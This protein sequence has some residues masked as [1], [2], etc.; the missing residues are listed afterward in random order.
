MFR[1]F[2]CHVV[3]GP[4]AALAALLLA[5]ATLAILAPRPLSAGGSP[6]QSGAVRSLPGQPLPQRFALRIEETAPLAQTL[7][8]VALDRDP[9]AASPDCELGGLD[10]VAAGVGLRNR[11]GGTIALTGAPPGATL[12]Q[13]FLYWAVIG[14]DEELGGYG[15]LA[16][17][18]QPVVGA[19]IGSSREPCW[20]PG[21]SLYAFRADVTA[22][23]EPGI[24]GDYAI[25]YPLETALVEDGRGSWSDE[26]FQRLPPAKE[27][28]T[29]VVVFRHLDMPEDSVVALHE[30]PL[31][32][33]LELLAEHDLETE[34]PPFAEAVRHT[35]VLADGQT[36]VDGEAVLPFTT[37]LGR[38]D[39]DVSDLTVIRGAGGLDPN[40]DGQ[41]T[42]GSAQTQL[43]E[44]NV[45]LLRLDA[46]NLRPGERKYHVHYEAHF[47]AA[48]QPKSQTGPAMSERAYGEVPTTVA[49]PGELVDCVVAV[50][51]A[52]TF[53]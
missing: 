5:G 6:Q 17:A 8:T 18:G 46:T 9:C 23:L 39:L 47:S 53:W 2:S 7:K 3:G 13:G 30:G 52:A 12:V 43:W 1:R 44:T 21:L 32:V 35:R 42:D 11:A 26:P 38:L 16:F 10:H 24:N 49:L 36:A 4:R 25:D 15:S 51:H 48:S 27:G 37:A 31:F 33:G 50:A 41:G 14:V 20:H 19:P 34:I 40:A 45:S 22:L 29:L 28:A